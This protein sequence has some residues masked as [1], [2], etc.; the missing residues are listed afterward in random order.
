MKERYEV[1]IR[2]ESRVNGEVFRQSERGTAYGKSGGWW[3]RYEENDESGAATK[4]IVK[5]TGEEW[6]VRR[7]GFVESAMSFMQDRRRE[8]YYRTAGIELKVI[9][10]MRSSRLEVKGGIGIASWEYEL[11]IGDAPVQYHGVTY[12]LSEQA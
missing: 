12:W 11:E 3:L 5:L 8:G 9:T 1:D 10:T 4:A 6:T 7:S 2:I